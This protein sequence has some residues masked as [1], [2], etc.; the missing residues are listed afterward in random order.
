MKKTQRLIALVMAGVL[1]L[2]LLGAAVFAGDD[3]TDETDRIET[4]GTNVPE[5]AGADDDAEADET[6]RAAIEHTDGEDAAFCRAGETLQASK[7][8]VFC[9]E[10]GTVYNNGATVYNN[11]GTVFN[12]LGVVFNNA[13]TTYNNSGTVYVNGG[14]VFN[15]AGTVFA[16]GGEVRDNTAAPAEKTAAPDEAAAVPDESERIDTAEPAAPGEAAAEP[17]ETERVGAAEAEE[18]AENRAAAAAEAQ[19][20]RRYLSFDGE[21]SL[22][23]DFGGMRAD[24][25]GRLYL[26]EDDELRVRPMAGFEITD[27][28]SS[29]GTFA[30]QEDGSWLLDDARESFVVTLSVRLA[31]PTASPAKGVFAP[32]REIK[33]KA[34]PGALIRYTL[35]GSEPDGNSEKY[36]GPIALERSA[37]LKARAFLEG[38]ESSESL[39]TSYTVPKIT[40]PVFENVQAGYG[41]EGTLQSVPAVVENDGTETVVIKSVKLD[42]KNAASFTLSTQKGGSVAPGETDAETWIVCPKSYLRAGT[43]GTTLIFTLSGGERIA[44]P[45]SFT[46]EEKAA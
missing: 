24:E 28:R 10:G 31:P 30:A 23:A 34:G 41:K 40:A 6:E 1:L 20:G 19:P 45:I 44:L 29:S 7:G 8:S 15:N 5:N 12:N 16:N 26:G 32:G 3:E 17:D 43:Y 33:L 18:S 13:G 35:D 22:Y 25:D 9:E 36:V 4:V 46:V 11:G 14:V 39:E 38:I 27:A 37:S 21:Y 2:S 42:G